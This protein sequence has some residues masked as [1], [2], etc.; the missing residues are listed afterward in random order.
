MTLTES[1]QQKSFQ[2]FLKSSNRLVLVTRNTKFFQ[3]VGNSKTNHYLCQM[4]KSLSDTQFKAGV[5]GYF[6]LSGVVCSLQRRLLQCTE[7]GRKQ[8]LAV[9]LGGYQYSRHISTS[10][11]QSTCTDHVFKVISQKQKVLYPIYCGFNA[12]TCI[13][14][15]P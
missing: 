9:G 12:V 4:L 2:Q 7:K 8:H 6:L 5:C 3:S 14:V 10:I 13:H 11:Y 1:V 15:L